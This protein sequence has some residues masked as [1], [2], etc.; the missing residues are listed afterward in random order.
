MR[1][2]TVTKKKAMVNGQDLE[3]VN[4][5]V[6]NDLGATGT[7]SAGGA[8]DDTICRLGKAKATF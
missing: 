7:I 6:P 8:D 1:F 2:N 4:S 5:F 3:D